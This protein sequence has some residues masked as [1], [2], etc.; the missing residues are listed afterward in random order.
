MNPLDDGFR[1][2]TSAVFGLWRATFGHAIDRG[3]QAG[4]VQPAIAPADSACA[5]VA[6]IEGTLSLARNSQDPA[7]LHVGAR[8]P[9]RHLDSMRGCELRPLPVS[10]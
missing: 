6:Q 7:D 3:Q 5:L 10:S 1:A 9:R 2:R 4:V 8:G